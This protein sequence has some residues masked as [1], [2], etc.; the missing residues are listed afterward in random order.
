MQ[1]YRSLTC[2]LRFAPIRFNLNFLQ[3]H[4]E[5]RLRFVINRF[6][7]NR[8]RVDAGGA[9]AEVAGRQEAGSFLR[10]ANASRTE[11]LAFSHCSLSCS[12]VITSGSALLVSPQPSIAMTQDESCSSKAFSPKVILFSKERALSYAVLNFREPNKHLCQL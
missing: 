2:E 9:E 1:P 3:S 12:R 10:I 5:K 4:H 7:A 11:C 8:G 6:I